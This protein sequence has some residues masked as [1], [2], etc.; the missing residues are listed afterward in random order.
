MAISQR[1]V[2]AHGGSI[3]AHVPGGTEIVVTLP[4]GEG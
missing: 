2:Q 4:T 1:I 3:Q